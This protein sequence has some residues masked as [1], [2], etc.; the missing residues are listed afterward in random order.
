M[1]TE[2]G[3]PGHTNHSARPASDG[4]GGSFK[5]TAGAWQKMKFKIKRMSV[6][7]C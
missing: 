6:I 2:I 4:R 3:D 5:M 7:Y 1:E